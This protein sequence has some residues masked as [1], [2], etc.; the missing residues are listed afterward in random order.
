MLAAGNLVL[1][2]GNLVLVA[3]NPATP[4]VENPAFLVAGNLAVPAAEIPNPAALAE[5]TQGVLLVQLLQDLVK[6][7]LTLFYQT[8]N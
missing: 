6:I 4:G 1:V 5:G 3:G 2:A 7:W 8:I